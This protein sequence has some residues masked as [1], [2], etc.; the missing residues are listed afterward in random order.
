MASGQAK[1]SVQYKGVT[2]TAALAKSGSILYQGAWRPSCDRLP[3]SFSRLLDRLPE[4]FFRLLDR[5]SE[6]FAKR[7]ACRSQVPQRDCLL[8][9]LQAAAD[10]R[11]AGRRRLEERI[12]RGC[13]SQAL[14]ESEHYSLPPLHKNCKSVISSS[15]R[16][17]GMQPS[18]KPSPPLLGFQGYRHRIFGRGGLGPV[19]LR[20]YG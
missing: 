13:A 9:L 12:L 10:A 17:W 1:L 6:H 5:L 8:D 11:Q 15:A 20:V 4:S 16:A 19:G 3:D 14:A 7:A 2:S 18:P